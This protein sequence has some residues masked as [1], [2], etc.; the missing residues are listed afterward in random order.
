MDETDAITIA[1]KT[2]AENCIVSSLTSKT[3]W[4]S[5][6]CEDECTSWRRRSYSQRLSRGQVKRKK[7][8][9]NIIF[10]HLVPS[11]LYR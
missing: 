6:E 7:V 10:S 9:G 5:K 8:R 3:G 1:M 4:L 11:A 2:E